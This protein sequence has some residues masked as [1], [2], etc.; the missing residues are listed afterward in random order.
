VLFSKLRAL[1]PPAQ[2]A[3]EAVLAG[4]VEHALREHLSP[5]EA[6]GLSIPRGDPLV[7]ISVCSAE[8]TAGGSGGRVPAG[9]GP[10]LAAYG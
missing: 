7:G 3:E 10:E 1:K 9:V 8:W 4:R 5:R 2:E 6:E